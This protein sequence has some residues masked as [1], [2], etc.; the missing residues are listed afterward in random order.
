MTRL[1]TWLSA[2]L[3][4][5]ALGGCQTPTPVLNSSGALEAF[6]P[7][8]ASPRDTCETQRAIARHNSAYDSIRNGK[9]IS[10]RAV[11]DAEPK[12]S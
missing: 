5:L 6:K 10:Y 3:V 12:T 8:A 2:A 4:A 11:C 1:L 7:I 9:P